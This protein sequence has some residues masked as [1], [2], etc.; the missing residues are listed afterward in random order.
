[1]DTPN[2]A[3][4]PCMT[5]GWIQ[6]HD[7]I[8]RLSVGHGFEPFAA[9]SQQGRGSAAEA[10]ANHDGYYSFSPKRGFRFLV[11]DTITDECGAPVCAEGSVDDP[12]FRWP[13]G[14]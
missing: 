4:F 9:G 6:Q 2:D 14:S 7:R 11:L 13:S 8:Y 12:Q 10:R 1:M 3:A 5:G